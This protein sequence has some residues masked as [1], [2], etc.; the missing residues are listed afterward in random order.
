M[1]SIVNSF[2]NLK[3][4]CEAE[5]FAGWDPYDGLNSKVFKATPLK[6]WDLARLAWIQ[7]FKRSPINFRKLLLVPKQHNAKGIGLFLNGYCNLYQLATK[8]EIRFGTKEAILNKITDLADLLLKMQHKD[9]SGACWGYNFDWQNRVFFQPNNTPTIVATSFCADAL[10][11][12]YE[13]TQNEKYLNTA[14]SACNFIISDLNRTKI[15][16][17]R[18][19]FSYSPLDS[20]QVYNASLLGARLLAR[21]YS[22]N[23]NKEWLKLSLSATQS[24]IEKQTEVGSWIYGENKV[25]SWIDSFH[26]G[27]NLEC[28]YE[29]MKYTKNQSFNSAFN[30]G[31]N[32]YLN[33]FFLS[34]GTP[35]Y[36]N[37]KIYP[38]DIHAPAQLITTLSRTVQLENENDLAI[39]V[40]NWTINNMQSSKGYFYYQLKPFVSSKLPYMRWAQASMFNAFTFYLKYTN[41]EDLD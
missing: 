2:K 16:E 22:Y 33:N 29:V 6:H 10:Y 19:I 20:S 24:I 35:K 5:N 41:N 8:G 14:L 9:Y 31:L 27:F 37:N 1:Q 36:Y 12:A 26:T 38:I 11:N 3:D 25:Q 7:G 17:N 34:D 40:L 13:I 32:Y 39:K 28:I 21:G 18:F 15:S 4:Y 30:K 23:K